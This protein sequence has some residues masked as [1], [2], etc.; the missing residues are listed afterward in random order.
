MASFEG[1][2]YGNIDVCGTRLVDIQK[3]LFNCLTA[4]D[5]FCKKHD[6]QYFL[7]GGTLLGAVRHGGFIPWDDDVDI[8]ML[9]DEYRRFMDVAKKE[10]PEG[11]FLQCTETDPKYHDVFCKLRKDGTEYITEFSS[12]QEGMHQGLF[13]DIFVHNHT[14]NTQKQQKRHVFMTLL[15]RSMVFHK[16]EKTPMQF[17][18]K[19]KLLCSLLTL[20]VRIT[21]IRI[22][23]KLRTCVIEKYDRRGY[24]ENLYDGTGMHL[25]N[26]AFPA[27]WL[28]EG[29][30]PM[31]FCGYEFPVPKHYDEYLRF[32]YGDD[33]MTPPPVEKRCIGHKLIR[34]SLG[35]NEV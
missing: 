14:G 22:L 12:T 3:E 24:A 27:G 17:Y 5:K 1:I 11:F 33:Y 31:S 30:V 2:E 28:L 9:P 29:T 18:G 20:L 34:V 13:I 10:P 4:V 23:E 21:S 26:G 7:G 19:Y 15:T 6:I 25:R 32:S 35:K 8:F 16:W